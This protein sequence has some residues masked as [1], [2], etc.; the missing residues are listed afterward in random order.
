MIG[1]KS[2]LSLYN[3]DF[4]NVIADSRGEKMEGSNIAV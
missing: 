3:Y 2:M 1:L 4:S